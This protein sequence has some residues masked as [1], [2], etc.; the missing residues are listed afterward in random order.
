MNV[1]PL[2]KSP[3]SLLFLRYEACCAYLFPPSHVNSSYTTEGVPANKE[4]APYRS[5][6]WHVQMPPHRHW[7]LCYCYMSRTQT[8][9]A[10]RKSE[11]KGQCETNGK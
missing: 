1:S 9:L 3:V 2:R 6:S 5:P 11:S 8:S 7:H 4:H 10:S